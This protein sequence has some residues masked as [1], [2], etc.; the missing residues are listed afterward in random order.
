MCAEKVRVEA[1]RCNPARNEPSI[2]PGGQ[3]T[4][5]ITTPTEKKL[6]RFLSG[7]FYV[8]VD[9]LPR[10]LCQL[11]PDWPTGLLLPHRRA[12]DGIPTRCNV[13]NPKCDDIAA[14]QLAVD[15]EIDIA[16]SRVRPSICSLVR[17]AQ[18]C[19]GRNGGF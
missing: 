12:I 5:V 2:L 7:S 4:A 14:P 6:A 17:I 16:K 13:L 8:I 3:A 11:K 15:C 1:D 18:T 10:L 19:F 9:G